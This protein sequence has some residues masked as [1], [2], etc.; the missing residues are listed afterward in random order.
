MGPPWRQSQLLS[1]VCPSMS[2]VFLFFFLATPRGLWDLSS[3]VE[4]WSP[5]HWTTGN[6]LCVYVKS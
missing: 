2:F 6:S 4:E 3:P 1:R 5:N